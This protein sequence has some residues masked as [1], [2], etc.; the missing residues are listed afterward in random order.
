MTLPA[1]LFLIDRDCAPWACRP[2]NSAPRPAVLQTNSTIREI[3]E[4]VQRTVQEE[5]GTLP[6]EL[7]PRVWFR[8]PSTGWCKV[9]SA[10]P[11]S[12]AVPFCTRVS[13]SMKL[14]WAAPL[15]RRTHARFPARSSFAQRARVPIRVPILPIS[16]APENSNF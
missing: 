5:V 10:V 7:P 12:P 3:G 2:C 1:I 4:A 15:L 13:A 16:G 9:P 8:N 6:G 11:L 14:L